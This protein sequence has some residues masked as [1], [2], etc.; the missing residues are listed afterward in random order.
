MAQMLVKDFHS[1][2][3]GTLEELIKLAIAETKK[4]YGETK[5]IFVRE[6]DTTKPMKYGTLQGKI[7]AMIQKEQLKDGNGKLC[8][9]NTHMYR[10]Y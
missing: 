7:M 2:V 3:P 10:H 4:R 5:Y 6:E 9:F 1:E 8:G